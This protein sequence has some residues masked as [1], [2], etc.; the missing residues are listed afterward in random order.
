MAK[1][2]LV[3]ACALA[4][5]VYAS[6]SSCVGTA[7]DF[8]MLVEQWAITECQD[9]FKCNASEQYFTLHGLW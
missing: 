7:S 6:Q 1:V 2:A 8:D 5:A 9:V 4:L 3:S